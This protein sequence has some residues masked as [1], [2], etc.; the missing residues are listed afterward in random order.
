MRTEK[1][2]ESTDALSKGVLLWERL[3]KVGS[4]T[5]LPACPK[6]F[7]HMIAY[8]DSSVK[9]SI[10]FVVFLQCLLV[11]ASFLRRS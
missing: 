7:V 5:L 3:E 2:E 4:I 1:E 9:S 6:L 8:V 11:W 10:S